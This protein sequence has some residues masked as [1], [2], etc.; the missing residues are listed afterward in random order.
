MVPQTFIYMCMVG[1][2]LCHIPTLYHYV[3]FPPGGNVT[4]GNMLGNHDHDHYDDQFDDDNNDDYDDEE[5]QWFEKCGGVL[6]FPLVPSFPQILQSPAVPQGHTDK[7]NSIHSHT[8]SNIYHC[9]A[10][11]KTKTGP[12]VC[13]CVPQGHTD[14]INSI[15]S[16][17]LS[18]GNI[19]QCNAITWNKSRTVKIEKS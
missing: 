15:R 17:T 2:W 5:E 13:R 19:Y 6:S 8:L 7:I 4:G 1:I 16:H 18:N 14:K 12:R 10:I 11:C 3:R 9:K